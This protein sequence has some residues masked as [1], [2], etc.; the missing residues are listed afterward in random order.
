M[1]VKNQPQSKR[2]PPFRSAANPLKRQLHYLLVPPDAVEP[3]VIGWCGIWR[4]FYHL[5]SQINEHVL[6]NKF[7]VRKLILIFAFGCGIIW[8]RHFN[9]CVQ[10]AFRLPITS[11]IIE[12]GSFGFRRFAYVRL[13]G[14]LLQIR[15]ASAWN[16]V[17]LRNSCIIIT[18]KKRPPASLSL[19]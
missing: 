19:F 15:E 11:F 6:G 8:N 2:K 18:E 9:F 14:C 13:H 5:Q 16:S 10:S 4:C 17:T 7:R 1:G 12:N 3:S